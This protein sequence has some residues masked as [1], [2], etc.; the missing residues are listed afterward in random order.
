[1]YA[2]ILQ[3]LSSA[4]QYYWYND[5]YWGSAWVVE[6]GCSIGIMN[7][8]TDLGGKAGTGK[9]FIKD[10]NW[11]TAKSCFG[12]Y[13]ILMYK[14]AIGIRLEGTFGSI[15]SYDSILRKV[16]P[17][18]FGRYERNLSFK[19]TITDFQ[20]SAEIHPLFFRRYDDNEAPYWSPY[21]IAGIGFFSFNPQAELNGRWYY[22]HP[23]HTEGQ[24]FAEY[25]D[26]KPYKL[27][28]LN[29]PLGVGIRY[30]VSPSINA[31][32]EFVHRILFTDYLDDVSTGYIDPAL[33]INYLPGTQ[34]SVAKQLQDRRLV[35]I[36]GSQR[37]DP[38]DK[39]AFFTIQLKVGIVIRALRR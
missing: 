28:Q 32:L 31:R 5:K 15:Q 3:P 10:I 18:T 9:G 6:T 26:R 27:V 34:A 35:V 33:F 24:G 23:L 13:A 14:E 11:K 36:K 17:S 12:I 1:V 19:T 4:A 39:D 22:L 2:C 8:L 30:E 20:F 25:P 38:G 7:C 37:G 29:I 21:L 16:A